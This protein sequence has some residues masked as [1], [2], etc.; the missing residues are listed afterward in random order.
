MSVL[1]PLLEKRELFIPGRGEH[2]KAGPTFQLFAT[3]TLKFSNS[4]G[5][6]IFFLY[7]FTIGP[8]NILTPFWT[9]VL[10]EPLS[11]V[12]LNIL[13]QQKYNNLIPIISSI[14]EIFFLLQ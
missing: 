11:Q 3:K 5:T 13:L 6:Y 8:S 9:K 14:V 1:L 7:S 12:E 10:I 4:L 2:I